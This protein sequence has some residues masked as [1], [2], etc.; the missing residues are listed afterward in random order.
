M[1]CNCIPVR[2]LQYVECGDDIQM[3]VA[4]AP[5]THHNLIRVALRASGRARIDNFASGAT[6]GW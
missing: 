6:L 1:R 3:R 5:R 4:L 2:R